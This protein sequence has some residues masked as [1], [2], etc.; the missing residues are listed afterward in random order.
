MP[1]D[2]LVALAEAGALAAFEPERRKALWAVHALSRKD[3]A[4]QR[5]LPLK[6]P[7]P[8]PRLKDLAELEQVNWDWRSSGHSTRAHLLEPV[9]EALRERGWPTAEEVNRSR[10]GR[11]CDYVGIVICRQR[12]LTAKGVTFMT[13][14]DET[15]FV[16]LVLWEQVWR[17]HKALARTLSLMGVSGRIQSEDGVVH[18]V[19]DEVW[20]P[21]LRREIAAGR[22]RDFR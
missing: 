14:E 6:D 17:E 3:R 11:P 20:D 5:L 9:R 21:R 2:D 12:P 19:V 22:S 1:V 15:G 16:N 18:L 8:A 10:H 4:E 7:A 13:L